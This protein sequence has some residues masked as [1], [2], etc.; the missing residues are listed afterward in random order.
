[1]NKRPVN[2]DLTTI[3]LPLTA[4]LSIM[5][6]ISG[7]IIFLGMPILLWMF[8]QS[9]SSEADFLYLQDLLDNLFFKLV[10]LG[11]LAALSYHI[12]AGIKHL[13]MDQ[14]IGES[15]TSAKIAARLVILFTVIAFIFLGSQL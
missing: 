8:G 15:A 1:V 10:F 14:G 3:R 6:R 4:V 12:I 2:L 11:I 13:F 9:L 7:V 5:H